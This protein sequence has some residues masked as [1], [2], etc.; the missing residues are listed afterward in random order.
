MSSISIVIPS[1]N[2]GQ[3]IGH[4]IDS[5][6]AQG[7]ADLDIMVIDGGSKDNTV[8]VLKGYGSRIGWVSERDRG[9]TDAINK[10]LRQAR[11]EIF[12][13]INSDDTY[14]P[15]TVVRALELFRRHP[16]VDFIYG[17]ANL[18]DE[19]G[20]VIQ[21]TRAV[22]F[23]IGILTYDHNYICQPA[24]FWRRSVVERVGMFDESL[25]YFMDYEWFLRAAHAGVP[26]M[27]VREAWANLRLHAS[28]KTVAGSNADGGNVQRV[29][30]EILNRYRR[31]FG[32][33]W[34]NRPVHRALRASYRGKKLLKDV[35]ENGKFP[36]FGYRRLMERVG[37]G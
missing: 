35:L 15:G 29:R 6:L 17:D 24:S 18:I 9:Q 12:A 21:R 1:Y 23:D 20:A 26:F 8:E 31:R 11:G 28:C 4:T 13:Y 5:I 19:G 36:A 30:E 34:I 32:P 22:D 33:P 25:Y 2:Q 7:V 27:H 3:F 10:G 14:E 37:A 16:K